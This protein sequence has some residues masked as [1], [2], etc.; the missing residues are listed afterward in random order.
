MTF[1]PFGDFSEKGYLRNIARSKD[2]TEIA[3]LETDSFIRNI[4]RAL[5]ALKG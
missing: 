4:E 2:R 1:D 5:L 3:I